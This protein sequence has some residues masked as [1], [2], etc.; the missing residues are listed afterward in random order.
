MI[1]YSSLLVLV[2][3]LLLAGA[4]CQ[5]SEE[6]VERLVDERIARALAAFPTSAA[7]G[8]PALPIT[9]LGQS[10]Q[11]SVSFN[12]VYR[13]VWPS[14]F[15]IEA[16]S[17]N[18]TGWMVGPG[19]ILT[20]HHLVAGETSVVVRQANAP[21]MTARITG[22][23]ATK[24]IALLEITAG[25]EHLPSAVQQRGLPT[26]SVSTGDIA[27]FVLVLGY[28]GSVGLT[29]IGGVGGATANVGVLSQ[30]TNFGPGS[31]GV[32]LT[33][34]AAVD[35]GD[36]GGPV[37]NLAGEVIGMIRLAQLNS[38][39][40]RVVGTFYGVHIEEIRKALPSLE[41]GIFID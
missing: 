38:G 6:E 22:W 8:R 13:E 28:S 26:A 33:I 35:P 27:S 17:G 31:Y 19:L 24:D 7:T 1:P 11:L 41:A 9:D 18:G 3:L 23:D 2:A 14:V 4:A 25:Q 10:S 36:S 21:P 20:V 29:S 32:N 16:H 15:R 39:G 30:I 40:Q 37:F 34:D 12:D 5:R